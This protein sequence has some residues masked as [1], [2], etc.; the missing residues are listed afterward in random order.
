MT[1]KIREYRIKVPF[2]VHNWRKG[3]RY[4]LAKYTTEDVQI[5]DVKQRKE[6]D[7][8]ITESHK[9]LNMSKWLPSVVKKILN[10]NAMFVDEF[11]TN[12][13]ILILQSD[14]DP[15]KQVIVT[16][17]DIKTK[18]LLK[19]MK[20]EKVQ[21]IKGDIAESKDPLKNIESKTLKDGED[22]KINVDLSKNK[23][24]STKDESDDNQST[25][26]STCESTY[27]NKHY[28]SETFKLT[29]KTIIKNE[30]EESVFKVK[31]CKT[32]FYDLAKDKES[33]C[34][35]YKLIQVTVNS[36]IFGWVADKI[37]NS[38]RDMLNKFHEKVIETESE[39]INMKEE[40]LIKL[41]EE[42][43]TKFLKNQ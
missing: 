16:T 22:K 20:I 14:T 39:W 41:E 21:E 19:E 23:K 34:Y 15:N 6:N 11:S 24:N 30:E 12:I 37:K 2:S 25:L 29:V 1:T 7:S 27:V 38:V 31:D 33:Y 43:V 26:T 42:M 18:G 32:Q 40:E 4:V 9:V 35:V 3:Q 13:D 36:M 8:I 17:K 28:D 5:I 10:E